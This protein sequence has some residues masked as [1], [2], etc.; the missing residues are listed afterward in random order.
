MFTIDDVIKNSCFIDSANGIY[1]GQIIQ[2]IAISNGMVGE[3]IE[4]D[5]EHYH[6]AWTEAEDW[7]N[8]NLCGKHIAFG[9]IADTGAYGLMFSH[10][11]LDEYGIYQGDLYEP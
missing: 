5:H 2:S 10:P 9:S 4:A 3:L 7:I 1:I 8:S 6:D 11:M